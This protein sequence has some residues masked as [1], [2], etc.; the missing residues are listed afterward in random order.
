MT[1]H[2]DQRARPGF[3]TRVDQ[4]AC[5]LNDLRAVLAEAQGDDDLLRLCPH[6]ERVEQGAVVYRA[7]RLRA[8]LSADADSPGTV[9]A[10]LDFV[11]DRG[12]GIFVVTGAVDRGIVARGTE[13][14][15][16]LITAEREAADTHGDHFAEAGA[17]DRVWNALEKL[18]VADAEVFVDYYS[19]DMIALGAMAW[20]GPGYQITSQVNVV[21]PGGKAQS[22]HRDYHLGFMTNERAQQ[23]P[24]AVHQ[25]S[26]RLT[27]Q[28]AVAHC[29]M[30]I[31]TGPTMY[32]P[33][34][35]KYPLG[36]LAWRRQDFIDFF[37]AHHVQVPLEAGDLVYFN[38]AL[39]HGA[40]TNR[41]SHVR[42]M[43]N[44]LQISSPLG[45][46]MESVDRLAMTK[47]V[48]PAL[49][50]AKR[51]GMTESD[52]ANAL[53]ACAEAYAFPT[54]LDRDPPV[55]GLT[56]LSQYDV[57]A[58]ALDVELDGP[59]VTEQLDLQAGRRLTR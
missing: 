55:G 58:E 21:R 49:L 32:L 20:L 33:H 52:L 24:L 13:A 44:L 50:A 16:A 28:G 8:A 43:A 5:D 15:E 14:F 45:R 40:G 26:P 57:T 27:L 23:Y 51:R 4:A 42:R 9:A 36:Y 48:Y 34:S 30:P 1:V 18:A 3:P 11:L 6:A 25:L 22:P 47:V 17:N 41:T 31:E 56:P 2:A 54:N 46:A 19:N 7:D 53:A 29:D 59:Q 10:E 37:N 38:P 39:F 35:Q 12:P